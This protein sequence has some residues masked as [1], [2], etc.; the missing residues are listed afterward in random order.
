MGRHCCS[1]LIE[2]SSLKAFILRA[3]CMD[4]RIFG[5]MKV[6]YWRR[7]FL[8]GGSSRGREYGIILQASFI[9]YSVIRMMFGMVLRNFIMRMEQ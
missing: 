4:L 3:G 2:K 1:M 9:A 7:A 8:L 5:T 6:R